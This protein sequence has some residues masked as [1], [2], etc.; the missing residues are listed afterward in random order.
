MAG[1]GDGLVLMAV[2][3]GLLLMAGDCDEL[4]LMAGVGDWFFIVVIYCKASLL[5][6]VWKKGENIY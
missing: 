1:V 5:D 4:V 3:D 6:F 2:G